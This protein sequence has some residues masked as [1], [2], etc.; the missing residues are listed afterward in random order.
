PV[1]PRRYRLYVALA[2]PWAHRAL[3]VR[4]LFG[5]EEALPVAIVAPEMLD[6]GWV[7]DAEHPDRFEGHSRLQDLYLQADTRCSSRVTVPVLWDVFEKTI[8]NN[9]SSEIIRMLAG[10]FAR[11][12]RKDAPLY[13]YDLRP[14]SLRDQ[15]EALNH[16][17]YDHV[18]NGVYKAGFATT[19]AAYDHAV[20]ALFS[21]LDE[22]EQ[23]L[24]TRRWLVGNVFTE[25]DLRL[26]P[27][28]VRFD[29]VYHAHFKCSLRMLRDYP[30][31]SAWTR[32][33][34]QLPGVKQTVDLADAKRH[35]FGSHRSINPQGII[36]VGPE[37]SFAA[38]TDRG[39]LGPSPV[40]AR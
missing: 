28:L 8:V 16:K 18:N 10:P 17:V 32:D 5:L 21:T 12:G 38:P 9:E 15:I 33:V 24:R 7:F 40:A 36:P 34:F 30:A 3:L 22:L 20:G 6:E 14:H 19:Q 1:D 29:A 27:T 31:L 13:G 4:T 35:Y 23:R 2:C 39:L 26:F 11:L 37:V 25:A